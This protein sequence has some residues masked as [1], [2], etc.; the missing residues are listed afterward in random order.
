MTAPAR[1]RMT[2]DEFIAWAMEQP[3]GERYELVAGE[4]VA[5]SP[6]RLSHSRVKH[7]IARLLEDAIA[8]A[9]LRCEA[10]PDGVRSRS[11]TT[12]STSRTRW[13]AA[14]S[15]CPA[16]RS[17]SCDP[18]IVVEVLSPST[19]ARDAGAKLEDY[20]RL[21]S[22][23]HYL[24]VKTDTRSVIHHRKDETGQIATRIVHSG[25]LELAPPGLV[26][27]VEACFL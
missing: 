23:R 4:V 10:L 5:M 26:V 7:R 12:R 2:S 14:A 13:C 9:G 1:R 3:D 25:E 18:I 11:T 8:A 6:E 22:V 16:T 20:F 17:S 19:R 24:I 15:R 21:P 27:E